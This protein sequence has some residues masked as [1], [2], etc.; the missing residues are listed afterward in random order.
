MRISN[1]LHEWIACGP[2]VVETEFQK[3]S[4]RPLD[5][6]SAVQDS[7][8]RNFL[9]GYFEQKTGSQ[10]NALQHYQTYLDASRK[11][12][13]DTRYYAQWQIGT[14]KQA[15]GEEWRAVEGRPPE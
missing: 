13:P 6:L 9:L 8:T 2:K 11:S 14:L 7:P 4:P 5:Y 15:L 1:Q 10:E 3:I 12:N